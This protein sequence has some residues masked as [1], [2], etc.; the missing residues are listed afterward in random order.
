MKI[1][2]QD[3]TIGSYS[4]NEA[5]KTLRTNLMFCGSD[6]K[7]I[8]FTSCLPAEGKTTTVMHL[9]RTLTEIGKRVLVIDGDMRR[10]MAAARYGV[11]GV[12]YGLSQY[13]SGQV[14]KKDIICETQFVGF[15][16]IFAGYYPPNPVELLDSERFRS[17]IAE[18]R[19]EYD[20]VLIDNPPVMEIVDAVVTAKCCDGAILVIAKGSDSVR[21]VKSCKQQIE[22]T[23]CPILG[24]VLNSLNHRKL[25]GRKRRD[26]YGKYF[27]NQ[28]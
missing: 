5:Y 28:E 21:Q 4:K 27:N 26:Y 14:E 16:I 17:F 6:K 12:Q 24:V 8:A 10:S 25:Y 13:L 18:V 15:Y 3:L 19:E 1:E 23:G 20:Y 9:A 22:K 7:V 2:L 11:T